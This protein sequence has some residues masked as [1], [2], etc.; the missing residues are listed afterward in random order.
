MNADERKCVVDEMS[1][2]D[3]FTALDRKCVVGAMSSWD[4]FSADARS[5]SQ[6]CCR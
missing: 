2:L 4:M 1:I 3:M 5:R 6:M